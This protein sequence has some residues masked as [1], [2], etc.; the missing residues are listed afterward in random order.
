LPIYKIRILNEESISL[1]KLVVFAVKFT[2]YMIAFW[3][4]IS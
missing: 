2:C 4:H 1:L 3:K